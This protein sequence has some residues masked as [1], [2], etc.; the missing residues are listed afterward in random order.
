MD[1]IVWRCDISDDMIKHLSNEERKTFL[2]QI[3][4]AVNQLGQLYKVGRE[5]E[6]GKL[7]ENNY[8]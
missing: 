6:N 4:D 1:R 8:A 2:N 7:K 5:Y 3:S